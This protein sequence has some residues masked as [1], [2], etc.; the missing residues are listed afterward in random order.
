[1]LAS[2]HTVCRLLPYR[3]IVYHVFHHFS[4]RTSPLFWDKQPI[5]S[6]KVTFRPQVR[7]GTIAP[8]FDTSE[9]GG[10]LSK[11]V[12]GTV[13][14]CILIYLSLR[15]M[16]RAGET[17]MWLAGLAKPLLIGIVTA[18]VL[19]VSLRLLEKLLPNGQGCAKAPVPDSASHRKAAV[20]FCLNQ[21]R[22]S[23]RMAE[24]HAF[25]LLCKGALWSNRLRESLTGQGRYSSPA[26]GIRG[27]APVFPAPNPEDRRPRKQTVLYR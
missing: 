4:T 23:N 22:F 15:H 21:V 6:Q 26:Q 14:C 16:D 27:Q 2:S 11:W 25:L 10:S 18:L 19:N 7:K 17:L 9:S 3:K 24:K 12:I 13:T 20:L 5:V 8:T 1:M